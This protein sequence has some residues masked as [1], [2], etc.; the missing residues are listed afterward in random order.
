[1]AA[2]IAQQKIFMQGRDRHGRG[3]II[4]QARKHKLTDN[5]T[6]QRYITYVIDGAVAASDTARNPDDKCVCIFELSG[7]RLANC[8]AGACQRRLRVLPRCCCRVGARHACMHR[9]A[10]GTQQRD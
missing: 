1:V 7:I 4:L 5:H 9:P 2:D 10:S 6:Q 3:V 8:D